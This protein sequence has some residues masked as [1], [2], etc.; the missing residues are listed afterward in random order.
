MSISGNTRHIIT[1]RPI[2]ALGGEDCPDLYPTTSGDS[3][4]R[5]D[6]VPFVSP[7]GFVR[8]RVGPTGKKV[9]EIHTNRF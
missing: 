3:P 1:R 8:F 4:V 9:D 7:L 2:P 5:K 6:S